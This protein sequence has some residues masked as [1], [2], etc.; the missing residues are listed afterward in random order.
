MRILLKTFIICSIFMSFNIFAQKVAVVDMQRVIT[1]VN[2]GKT[3]MDQLKKEASDAEKKMKKQQDELLKL[4]KEIQEMMA[5]PAANKN[6]LMAK[7]KEGQEKLL[8]FQ[9]Q[10]Q[11]FQRNLSSK[12]RSAAGKIVEKAQMVLSDLV[13]KEKYDMVLNK[14]AVLYIADSKDITT[15]VIHEYNKVYK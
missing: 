2:E 12:E 6:T 15:K 9:Q 4:Q 1:E 8:V 14:A 13:K 3:I 10:A 7:Q 5:N 11:E